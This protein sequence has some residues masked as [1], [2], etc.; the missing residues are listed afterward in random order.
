MNETLTTETA[1]QRIYDH[2]SKPGAQLLCYYRRHRHAEDTV[3]CAVG[4]L[5]P[6]NLYRPE[7]EQNGIDDLVRK[8]SDLAKALNGVP[9][10]TLQQMQLLHDFAGDVPEFLYALRKL[11]E[12]DFEPMLK[13]DIYPED[14]DYAYGRAT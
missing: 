6:D 2:F 14:V 12:R 3:R 8:H 13:L 9:V 7:M 10:Q 11:K 1:W 5:I 4:V